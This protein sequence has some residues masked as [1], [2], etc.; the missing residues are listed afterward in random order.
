MA[1]QNWNF[2]SRAFAELVGGLQN[3]QARGQRV[4]V[5]LISLAL[6]PW[7]EAMKDIFHNL[8]RHASASLAIALV[9]QAWP[10]PLRTIAAGRLPAQQLKYL[11]YGDSSLQLGKIDCW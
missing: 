6:A 5:K 3:W 4:K 1:C 8:H 10:S 9:D 11:L 2:I 7:L